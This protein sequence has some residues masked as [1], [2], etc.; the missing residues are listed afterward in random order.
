MDVHMAVGLH[1][2]DFGDA[3]QR[4]TF[5]STWESAEASKRSHCSQCRQLK[6]HLISV[7]ICSLVSQFI[8]LEPA[9]NT[10]QWCLFFLSFLDSHSICKVWAKVGK[11]LGISNKHAGINS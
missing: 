4:C 10:F 8:M 5:R 6:A 3:S 9:C 2:N 1:G 7:A 11:N